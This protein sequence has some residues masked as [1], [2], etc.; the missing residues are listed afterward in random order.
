MS[1]V[2]L[3]GEPSYLVCRERKSQTIDLLCYRNAS[4]IRLVGPIV[5]EQSDERAVQRAGYMTLDTT[6]C[7]SNN[8]SPCSPLS[9]AY[10]WLRAQPE[11]TLATGAYTTPQ[12]MIDLEWEI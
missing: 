11:N 9:P 1:V 4:I 12:D 8:P 7:V 10:R 2:S 5:L 6:A 3:I